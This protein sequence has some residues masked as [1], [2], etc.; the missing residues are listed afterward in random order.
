MLFPSFN[1]N[2]GI[3]VYY[4]LYLLEIVCFD[5][6]FLKNFK[7]LPVLYELSHSS[8]TFYMYM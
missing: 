5:F 4:I 1:N 7:L 2:V 3:L 6:L 8:I